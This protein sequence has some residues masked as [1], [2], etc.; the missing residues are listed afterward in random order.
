[1]DNI[2]SIVIVSLKCLKIS[3]T[4]SNPRKQS[5]RKY[6]TSES[7]YFERSTIVMSLRDNRINCSHYFLIESRRLNVRDLTIVQIKLLLPLDLKRSHIRRPTYMESLLELRPLTFS[8]STY[9]FDKVNSRR[10]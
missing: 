4:V 5:L 10:V 3:N 1:M 6:M 9:L 7:I 2:N 8:S